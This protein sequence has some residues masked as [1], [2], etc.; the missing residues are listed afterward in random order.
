SGETFNTTPGFTTLDPGDDDQTSGPGDGDGDGGGDTSTG[1]LLDLPAGDG[2][3]DGDPN[4]CA[5]VSEAAQNELLPVDIIFVVDTSGSMTE[6]KNFV[7]QNMNLF[8]QQ[9]FL[10]NIDHHVVMIADPSPD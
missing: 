8:S 2:D 5:A 10:A 4:E 6:E 3:G 9:I 7:Q 1:P